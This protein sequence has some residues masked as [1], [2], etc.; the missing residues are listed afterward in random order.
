MEIIPGII[1][2]AVAEMPLLYY[3]SGQ[4]RQYM[5]GADLSHLEE[6]NPKDGDGNPGKKT[7]HD[8]DKENS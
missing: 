6:E 1:G 7:D 3:R 5:C 2:F 8:K 4:K